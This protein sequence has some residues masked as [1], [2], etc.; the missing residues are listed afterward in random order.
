MLAT[1]GGIVGKIFGLGFPLLRTQAERSEWY[2]KVLMDLGIPEAEHPN[3][4]KTVYAIALIKC[5]AELKNEDTWNL[6]GQLLKEETIVEAFRRAF[7]RNDG[8]IL[9]QA[10]ESSIEQLA[11]GDEIREAG[12]DWKPI[13][14]AFIQKFLE[15]AKRSQTP[16]EAFLSW[17]SV[18]QHQ[19][20]KQALAGIERNIDQKMERLE[21]GIKALPGS[22]AEA[23]SQESLLAQQ[24]RGW[25]KAL[26]YEFEQHEFRGDGYFEWVIRI[27]QSDPI[28]KKHKTYR[29]VVR[30]DEDAITL[31]DLAELRE[32]VSA[33]RADGGWLIANRRVNAAVQKAMEDPENENLKACTL[34]ELI[35]EDADFS[36]YVEEIEAEIQRLRVHE[37]YVPLAC[38]K[39]EINLK[40]QQKIGTSFYGERQG[41]IESYVD[42]WLDDPVKEHVSVLGEFGTGKTWFVLHYAWLKLQEYKESKKTGRNRSRLPIVIRLRDYTKVANIE[43]LFSD[44]FFNQ[45][46]VPLQGY[47]AFEQLNKMGK[48]LL[49][50]DGFDE[51]AARVDRQQMVNQFWELARVV[52]PGSKVIL[53]CRTEH[54]PEA[55]EGRRLLGAEV[56]AS[57]KA[58]TIESPKFEVLELE[59]LDDGQIRMMLSFKATPAVIEKVMGNPQLL[60][61]ARRPVMTE[62]VIEALPEI[63]SGKPIDLARVYLYAVQHKMARDI[64]S[65][66]TFTSMA[67]KLYFLCELSWE[68]L[69]SDRMSLN[70]REF[71]DQLRRLFGT[72]VQEDKTLDH[73]HYDMM[74]QSMLIRNS[75]GDYTPAHRSLLEFFVAY[76]LVA[77]LGLMDQDF[78][79]VAVRSD[80]QLDQAMTAK[81][82]DWKEYFQH[83]LDDQGQIMPMAQISS[84]EQESLVDIYQALQGSSLA[85]AVLDLAIPM[86]DSEM[87]R[88]RLLDLVRTT[89]GKALADA[90][91]V[92]S[93]AI[94][95]LLGRQ[96]YALDRSD[97]RGVVLR[98]LNLMNRSLRQADLSESLL[99]G[100]VF[101]RVLS[102]VHSVAYS[103][104]GKRMAIGDSEGRLQVWDVQT[105]E[106]LLLWQ[107]HGAMIRSVVYSPDG[108]FIASGSDD[109]T[110]KVWDGGS[111]SLLRTLEGHGNRVRSV[112][113]S[114]DGKSIVSG[115]GDK[116]VKVW[117]GKSGSLLRTL[118]DHG[119][120]V[121]S[122]VYSPDG[123]SIASGS[124]DHTV[125]IWDGDS[126]SLSR[127]LE[128]H[129]AI[130][131]SVVYSP[132]GKSIA[133][134]SADKTVKV[135][136]GKSGSLLRTLED[137]GASVLSVVYSPDGKSIASGSEGKTI[138]VWDGDSGSL[139]HTLE[140]HGANVLSV[141]YSP[142]GKSIASGSEDKT[143]KV[144]D[145]KSGSLLRTL[146]GHGNRV[147]SVVYSPDGKSIVS[148]SEDKTI[149]VWDGKSGSLLR[150]LEGHE[151]RVLSVV[152]SPDGKSIVSGSD[153]KTIKV[154][155]GDSGSLL[156]TLEGHGDSVFFVVYSPDGKSIAS[157]SADKTVKVWDGDNGSLLRSLE[158]HG[159]WVLSIVYSP[160]GKSI[161]S[162]SADK[163]VKVWDGGS[164]SL[165]HTL[166]GHG[167]WVL[168]VV[169]SPDG[170][171]IASGSADKTIKIWDRDNGSLLRSLECHGNWVLSIVYSPDGKS[172][173]SGSAD[174]TVKV[175]D[176]DSGS[177]LHTLEGHGDWVRSVV[178][179]PD[180]TT[181]VSGSD[182]NTVRVWDVMTGE[183]LATIDSRLYGKLNITGIKGLSEA[184]RT[185]LKAYGALDTEEGVAL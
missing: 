6:M 164:G 8:A 98:N 18:N 147:R 86:L 28:R 124:A 10:V 132:N 127:T 146:E 56:E 54:F 130:V 168:S 30:G 104:D 81:S 42:Q 157:G 67:D 111:G 109:N 41:W 45:Y 94:E 65:E 38:C 44:F 139:L 103:P 172:I 57:T 117:D 39:D 185:T 184:Q 179:S 178:Y 83:R 33:H 37:C 135:W 55:R 59:K 180:G 21:A 134:G 80:R 110:V 155:D 22:Q 140:G 52:V 31:N 151:N 114:P 119:A 118:E 11:L 58:L 128:G 5:A 32:A 95:L 183:C 89:R 174:H 85:K 79:T 166:E 142:D 68:M 173:A 170:T 78:M 162:G 48:L 181:I 17:Q 169:Y 116:T 15:T 43:S 74:G 177:L 70:Y 77:M 158:G 66:R 62:L 145:G 143:I 120:S 126:G 125:K 167:D 176:R 64:K 154:W 82:Y 34:D 107:G 2:Q 99:S 26:H 129:G 123:K 40:T 93:N 36:R 133:S 121:L 87:V 102:A 96:P 163:T 175:W 106:V 51:M 97:L 14:K 136:D 100:I 131:S 105:S 165:L 9:Q 148:G 23:L 1:I 20:T 92:G 141:V 90:G 69:K 25:L 161:A 182:D 91:Y 13:L 47:S 19:Q 16:G 138:K 29:I 53:T 27:S 149:K 88:D 156:R 144:W 49:I 137:H 72:V 101:N 150:T 160:D 75:E 73:W 171:T 159:N 152:Y 113:Y 24:L 63:E 60:D 153:D 12:I 112:I 108:K 4:F 122:V 35:D 50:F 84:F 61:L 46:E 76:R 71:P 115:S 7:D 3:D